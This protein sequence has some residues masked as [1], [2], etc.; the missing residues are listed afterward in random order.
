MCAPAKWFSLKATPDKVKAKP[1][2]KPVKKV[3]TPEQKARD[4]KRKLV[5]AAL[6]EPKQMPAT[7]Y[8]VLNAEMTSPGQ[9]LNAKASSE[10]YRS[11]SS[12]EREVS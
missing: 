7:A 9:G 6:K 10:R 11:L 3:V 1:K 4:E 8:L 12:S 5:A 2:K